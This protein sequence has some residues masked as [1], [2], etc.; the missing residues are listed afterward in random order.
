MKKLIVS[1]L[2]LF[3]VMSVNSVQVVNAEETVSKEEKTVVEKQTGD[4]TKDYDYVKPEIERIE[5]SDNGTTVKPGKKIIVKV[6]AIDYGV[7]IKEVSARMSYVRGKNTNTSDKLT[8]N[9]NENSNTYE[10]E[11]IVPD[12]GYEKG[13]LS[14]VSVSDKN[15]NIADDDLY[16]K[17]DGTYLYKFQID[18]VPVSDVVLAEDAIQFDKKGSTLKA[19]DTIAIAITTP[20]NIFQDF[21]TLNMVFATGNNAIQITLNKKINNKFEGIIDIES[22][23]QAGEYRLTNIEAIKENGDYLYNQNLI[24]PGIDQIWY[25]VE[26]DDQQKPIVKSIEIDR[27]GEF[28]K[29]GE[30]IVVKMEID[31]NIAIDE[32]RSSIGFRPAV[33][34]NQQLLFAE[35]GKYDKG[36]KTMVWNIEIPKK[37]YLCEWFL[38]DIR[39]YDTSGNMADVQSLLPDY[40][41]KNSPYY[42]KVSDGKNF[43]NPTYKFNYIFSR[44]NNDG[45]Y[46]I[47]ESERWI[48]D[49]VERRKTLKEVGFKFPDASTTYEGIK[50]NCWKDR[51]G[52]II[53][54]N[55]IVSEW[56]SHNNILYACYDKS[57]VD[58]NYN[59][60]NKE[61]VSAWNHKKLVVPSSYN[62]Q[63]VIDSAKN[64][65][66][67]D[68]FENESCKEWKLTN[69]PTDDKWLNK[70]VGDRYKNE[71]LYYFSF[72][73]DYG[74][75][76]FANV[77][78]HYIDE[79]GFVFPQRELVMVDKGTTYQDLIN[80][81][82]KKKP[83]LFQDLRF[84]GWTTDKDLNKEVE[85]F[86]DVNIE[87]TYE[88]CFVRFTVYKYLDGSEG[89]S[90]KGGA[91]GI[92]DAFGK[93]MVVERGTKIEAPV[94]KNYKD[95][96]WDN[97][98]APEGNNLIITKNTYF[99]GEWGKSVAP[100]PT[101]DPTPTPNPDT[102]PT[103]DTP[104]PEKPGGELPK[105][106]VKKIVNE[107][108]NAV[109]GETIQVP[110]N[111][112][113]VVPVDALKSAQGKDVNIVLNMGGY[114]WTINGKDI[115]SENLT[116][117]NLEIEEVKNVVSNET[118]K[119]LFGDDPVKQ[120]SLTHNGN[121]GFKAKLTI[122]MGK[123]NTGKYGNLYYHDSE[124]KLVFLNAG[125]IDAEGNVGL[126]FSHASEYVIVVS[127]KIIGTVKEPSKTTT[128]VIKKTGD[129]NTGD[130]TMLFVLTSLLV[131]SGFVLVILKK[132]KEVK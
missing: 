129:V 100:T 16:N 51:D 70:I 18:S 79:R 9:L 7:G 74:N 110:M 40:L 98:F 118:A 25:K 32:N 50:F 86:G 57:V 116:N 13:Y 108:E 73:A 132:K 47:V 113:T 99:K 39:I 36:L 56:L 91:G 14:Y 49:N 106:E 8:L 122:N 11:F 105:E 17:S 34:T 89:K 3:M 61:S 2:C 130:T 63:Q 126:E 85:D 131:I 119:E 103:P 64:E 68:V 10:G 52:N 123:E 80:E 30:K 44:L 88:N 76:V 41:S 111:D 104:E 35:K 71:Y 69:I 19:N 97:N 12:N 112:A 81:M 15:D 67:A 120:I 48:N 115:L 45:E 6:T 33:S 31:E 92:S 102:E 95:I 60:I 107:I 83:T 38:S 37:T 78:K 22:N 62:F 5:F 96:I 29:P 121:F 114:T 87:A 58:V 82:N 128:D 84:K 127:D 101:P 72:K 28:V 117:I 1:I 59:Y 43:V 66:K 90:R 23:T 42:I 21:N 109:E 125:T 53:D 26:N 65:S 75:K 24:Y 93:S 54:E 27:N 46:V 124:G 55:T 20:E 4:K 94:I 77:Q